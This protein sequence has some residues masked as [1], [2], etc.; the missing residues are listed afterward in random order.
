MVEKENRNVKNLTLAKHVVTQPISNFK[1][2]T[3]LAKVSLGIFFKVKFSL[4]MFNNI[5][6]VCFNIPHEN[7]L[8]TKINKI[9]ELMVDLFKGNA[10]TQLNSTLFVSNIEKQSGNKMIKDEK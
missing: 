1:S 5:Y 8:T 3:I 9:N 10:S 6:V 7:R 4:R 2:F